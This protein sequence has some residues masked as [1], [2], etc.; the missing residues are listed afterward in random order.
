MELAKKSE[1]RRPVGTA[2]S[3]LDLTVQLRKV[4]ANVCEDE[5]V[6]SLGLLIQSMSYIPF[7]RLAL[8][9]NTVFLDPVL[10]S[11]SKP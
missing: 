7:T 3:R 8:K 9:I 10:L 6:D 5:D 2:G 11:T 4:E 1:A